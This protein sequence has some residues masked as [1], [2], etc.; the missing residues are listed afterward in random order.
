MSICSMFVSSQ[1][2]VALLPLCEAPVADRWFGLPLD[3]F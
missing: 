1:I 3:V 2:G